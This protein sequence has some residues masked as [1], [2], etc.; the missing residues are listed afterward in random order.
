MGYRK[1][2]PKL[3]ASRVKAVSIEDAWCR[4]DLS[5]LALFKTTKVIFGTMNSSSSR[6]ETVEEMQ[7]RLS[8]ALE[9]IDADRLIVAP[10]CGLALLDGKKYRPLLN[11]KL[12]N[13]CKAADCV[14]CSLNLARSGA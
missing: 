2:A 7:E 8:A 9:Y 14:P 13:M 11:L 3:D 12:A 5:L 1:I 6:I 4:N 10:D